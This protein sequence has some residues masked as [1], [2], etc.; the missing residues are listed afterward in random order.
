M[1]G[2]KIFLL[3]FNFLS[4]LLF[5]GTVF[6]WTALSDM[7]V[8]ESFYSY[9]CDGQPPC[10]AQ[11]VA[12]NQA[13][14]LASTAT[15][16]CA[17]PGGWLL[18]SAG[19]VVT[20]IAG[21]AIEVLSVAG[22]ALC[23]HT[24]QLYH[25]DLFPIYL[26]G[27]AVGGSLIRFCGYSCGFL[28]PGHGAL[29]IAMAS[30]LFDGSC[31]VF[32]LIKVLYNMG[33][34]LSTLFWYYTAIGLVIFTLLPVAWWLNSAEM[35]QVR[36]AAAAR[37]DVTDG[38]LRS[39]PISQQVRTLEF[40]AIFCFSTI[41][42]THSN[43]YIGSVNDVNAQLAKKTGS[44]DDLHFVNTVVSFV[45]PMGFVAVPAITCSIRR[46]GN[47]G[48]VQITNVLGVFVNAL[49]LIPS[50]YL[51]LLTVCM[52]A[53]FRAYLFSNVPQ[54]NAHYFGVLNMGRIQGICFLAGGL[55]NL[56]QVPLINWS[57]ISLGGYFTPLVCICIVA[58]IVPVIPC[59]C[60]QLRECREARSSAPNAGPIARIPRV[61]SLQLVGRLGSGSD[62]LGVLASNSYGN[63]T[64]VQVQ[65]LS[66]SGSQG[67]LHG[68]VVSP[69]PLAVS[70][71]EA[72]AEG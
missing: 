13:F 1:E 69:D 35:K 7:L 45:I 58:T 5:A 24:W 28:F 29:L 16:L 6:G 49:Q 31:M 33:I 32:P 42:L 54:F 43:L 48:T 25:I 2:R 27:V 51:Q 38:S 12:L 67:C 23:E 39:K 36:R 71:A 44:A 63:T 62:S 21:G 3:C 34:P 66:P 52:F 9:L 68:D 65:M 19:P 46:F 26:V 70:L 53:A 64:P 4:I 60:L 30:V 57:I 61:S 22:I 50:L 37:Q 18:D 47:I 55:F 11:S 20:I 59:A 15:G 14:T 10:D 40:L 41:Q 17:L 72:P 8:K 56:V